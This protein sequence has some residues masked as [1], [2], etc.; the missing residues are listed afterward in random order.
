MKFE[1]NYDNWEENE[2]GFTILPA[3]KYMFEIMQ[4]EDKISS[5]NDEMVKVTFNCID[6][7]YYGAPIWD[8]ILFPRPGSKAEK[9]IGRTKRFLHCLGEPYQ[10]DFEV[11]TDNWQNKTI[12][13]QV[14][15]GEY[16]DKNGNKKPKNNIVKYILNEEILNNQNNKNNNQSI[17]SQ[18][19]PSLPWVNDNDDDDEDEDDDDLQS[20][21]HNL[22]F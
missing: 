8:N 1:R 19:K 2:S 14:S 5:N 4:T 18:S 15:V 13:I 9:I 21:N 16:E 20:K 10:G 3:G 6:D 17:K 22:P 12:E 7:S 11:D